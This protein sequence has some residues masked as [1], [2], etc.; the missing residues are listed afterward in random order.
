MGKATITDALHK[1]SD[2][3][4]SIAEL[5]ILK[6]ENYEEFLRIKQDLIC[7]SCKTPQLFP[8]LEGNK[9]NC[10]TTAKNQYHLSECDYFGDFLSHAET[11]KLYQKAKTN[12]KYSKEQMVK[13]LDYVF[14]L[15]NKEDS[16]S[17]QSTIQQYNDTAQANT[18]TRRHY[19]ATDSKQKQKSNYIPRKSLTRAITK[20]DCKH[21]KVYY[22]EVN[23]NLFSKPRKEN[24]SYF[25]TLYYE[26][27]YRLS[28]KISQIVYHYLQQEMQLLEK[29]QE[30]QIPVQLAVV[31]QVKKNGNFNNITVFHS[32]FLRVLPTIKQA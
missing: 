5:A 20:E 21:I 8:R 23:V 14:A 19:V 32:S 3:P 18:K 29:S 30:N 12:D 26:K 13:N 17:S 11:E 31:G 25:I 27:N 24:E 6:N 16:I 4:Y 15:M 22:G 7:N 10:F 1:P 9:E 2:K 28:L